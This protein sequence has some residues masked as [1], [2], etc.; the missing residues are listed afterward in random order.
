MHQWSFIEKNTMLVNDKGTSNL[1]A[2]TQRVGLKQQL[3]GSNHIK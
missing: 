2:R 3:I 1:K